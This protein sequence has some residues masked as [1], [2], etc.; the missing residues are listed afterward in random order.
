MTSSIFVGVSRELVLTKCRLGQAPVSQ[1]EVTVLIKEFRTEHSLGRARRFAAG[2]L[3]ESA[4]LTD[5]D[6][7]DQFGPCQEITCLTGESN[8]HDVA[9]VPGA[10]A[11]ESQRVVTDL[12]EVTESRE[13]TRTGC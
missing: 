12:E 4:A 5:Q 9:V 11:E 6:L 1:P 13:A 10:T 7:L 8:A 3:N 2:G